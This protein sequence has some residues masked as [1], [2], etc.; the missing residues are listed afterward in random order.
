MKRVAIYARYSSENQRE[1]SIDD[2]VRDCRR[3][4]VDRGWKVVGVYS[5]AAQSGSSAFRPDFSRLEIDARAGKFDVVLAEALDRLSRSLS[6]IAAFYQ[7]LKFASVA[8]FTKSE[9]EISDLHVGLLGTMNQLFLKGLGEKVKRGQRGRTEAGKIAGGHAYGYEVL[10]G[11]VRGK[12]LER[13]DRRIKEE[14]AAVIR[15][16]FQEFADG[17]GPR[18][19]AQRLNQEGVPGPGGRPWGD[20]TIRGQ[21]DRGTGILN[22]ACYVG[23]VEWNRCSY[24]KDPDTG[25]RLA[26]PN[27]PDQWVIVQVPELRI[28]DDALWNAVKQRQGVVKTKMARDDA[29]TPLN[30][31]HRTHH[32]LSGLIHCGHCGGPMAITA[33][34]RYG[35]STRRSKRTCENGMTVPREDI[36]RRVLSGLKEKLVEPKLVEEFIREFHAEMKLL[37]Q[38]NSAARRSL[39]RKL[40][41]VRKDIRTLIE[42]LKK[43]IDTPDVKEEL[44]LLGAQRQDLEARLTG[45]TVEETNVVEF[46]PGLPALYRQKIE[47]FQTALQDETLRREAMAIL[48][49][50]I[51][52]VVVTPTEASVEVALYG[53]LGALLELAEARRQ[54]RPGSLGPRRSLSV[55]A[56]VGFEP[57]TFRL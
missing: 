31:A 44:E 6:D 49:T 29:G 18:K 10:P 1:A 50:L 27:L 42:A 34:S 43:G 17:V 23:R 56:G 5:D 54:G 24:V 11:I 3:Y 26:R 39:E 21:A 35:C 47:Q 13:G 32:L 9:G 20:T 38:Q 57:T 33:V 12:T 8:I 45:S 55:V 30:R 14:E 40:A 19:I 36:E 48:R 53:E 4:A 22:N 46:H 41:T 52:K 7:R 15:R 28:L 51:E 2:Q 37:K 16:I 25:K